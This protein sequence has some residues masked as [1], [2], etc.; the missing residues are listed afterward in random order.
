MIGASRSGDGEKLLFWEHM[1]IVR[2]DDGNLAFW[3][4]SAD[5]RP[6]RFG[7]VRVDQSEILF[8]NPAHDYPQRI[9]YWHEQDM[10]KA[11]I[12]LIDGTKAVQF[13]F[14]RLGG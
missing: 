2:E 8:E 1:R 13:L 14:A 10:L 12:A 4:I 7:A 9:R 11:E 3:A 5:Q 6:V